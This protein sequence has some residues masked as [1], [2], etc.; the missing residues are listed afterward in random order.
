MSGT[1]TQRDRPARHANTARSRTS[2]STQS[3]IEES[4]VGRKAGMA[5]L[6]GVILPWLAILLFLAP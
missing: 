5:I 4:F 2:T 1:S 3:L 6:C